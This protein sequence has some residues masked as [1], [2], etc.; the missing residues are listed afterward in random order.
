[1]TFIKVF[2]K[3]LIPEKPEFKDCIALNSTEQFDII[4]TIATPKTVIHLLDSA[5]ENPISESVDAIIG[6]IA[7]NACIRF[8]RKAHANFTFNQENSVELEVIP[9]ANFDSNKLEDYANENLPNKDP[10]Q[11]PTESNDITSDKQQLPLVEDLHIIQ[12]CGTITIDQLGNINL[13]DD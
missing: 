5:I 11:K 12:S 2:S 13:A 1:M 7:C 3:Q 6:P 4:N 8:C 10:A 9:I